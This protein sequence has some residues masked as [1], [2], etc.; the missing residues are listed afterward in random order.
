MSGG[1]DRHQNHGLRKRC[2]CPRRTW[3]KCRHSWWIDYK[4]RGGTRHYQ[5]SLDRHLGRHIDSKTA[6]EAEAAALRVSID[7]GTFRAPGDEAPVP[8]GALTVAHLLA[9]YERRV[10]VPRGQQLH[11]AR[12][13]CGREDWSACPH[14]RS[15][16]NARS[17]MRVLRT[18]VLPRHDGRVTRFE[19]WP[20]AD[21]TA[22]TLAQLQESRRTGVRSAPSTAGRAVGR[23]VG[24]TAAANRTLT[25][26]RAAFSWAARNGSTA[27]RSNGRTASCAWSVQ[28]RPPNTG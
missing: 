28:M 5:F 8:L 2:D 26:L 1:V 24:G 19:H 11:T 13:G 4:P 18:T 23:Q 10:L 7:R 15:L 16:V 3:A 6:A 22:D 25:F 14:A 9:E 21:I 17:L 20:V 27:I 12:C